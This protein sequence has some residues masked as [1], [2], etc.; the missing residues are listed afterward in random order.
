MY[1]KLNIST[2]TFKDSKM[3]IDQTI[4]NPQAKFMFLSLNF[5]KEIHLDHSFVTDVGS[6]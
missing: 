2:E 6:K 4:W 1:N 3:L 5:K